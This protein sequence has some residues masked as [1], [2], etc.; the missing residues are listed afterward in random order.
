MPVK[1]LNDDGVEQ[2][3]FTSEE[4]T[5]ERTRAET[6]EAAVKEAQDALKQKTDDLVKMKR[7]HE[8]EIKKL[9]DMSEEEKGKLTADQI[10]SMQRIEALEGSAKG[11][12][13][14]AK[15]A[16]FA[17]AAKGDVKVLEK[18]KEKYGMVTM[19]EGT[20]TEITARINSIIP[21]AYSEMGI[22]ERQ[23]MPLESVIVGGGD[24]PRQ[25]K[26]GGTR[27]ADTT[28]GKAIADEI[29]GSMLPKK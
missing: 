14:A 21:W 27:F 9:V 29:F 23:P 20:V 15:E 18:L 13:E 3:A 12:R 7:G 11:D 10:Q 8:G 2:E 28:Q 16:M 5:A 1:F 19:P 6:A 17:A 22:V 4:L 25:R 24:A 26:E